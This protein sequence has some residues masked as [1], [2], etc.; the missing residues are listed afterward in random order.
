MR[1][2]MTFSYDGSKYHGYQK[3]LV[4]N[5]IQNTIENALYKIAGNQNIFIHATG[6]TDAKVHAY[7]QKA[8]FDLSFEILPDKLKHSLN[9]L[10]PNDIYIKKVEIVPDT[11]HARFDIKKKEYI[12]KLNMGEYNP[13]EKDYVCQWNKELNV[14][15]MQKAI[16]YLKGSHNF[17]SFTKANNDILDYQ[18]TIIEAQIQYIPDHNQLL[19]IFIG[20]GFLRYQIRNMVGT[21]LEIG[22]GKKRAQEINVILKAL[23]RKRAGITAPACGLYLKDVYYE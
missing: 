18:R 12:Y 13:L 16:V 19:F 14:K 7:N 1:Y 5:T 15:E 9:S 6:R 22:E 10:L 3:Q 21:L 4:G 8:H 23:D 11:F 20:T 17:K 2:L